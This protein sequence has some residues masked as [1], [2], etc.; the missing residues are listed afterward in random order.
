MS[1]TRTAVRV[2]VEDDEI[3]TLPVGNKGQILIK[4]LDDSVTVYLGGSTVSA[5]NGF[6][7]EAGEIYTEVSNAYSG[8]ASLYAISEDGTVEL[9]I[10]VVNG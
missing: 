2:D 5:A 4:N 7:L 3:A 10:M 1:L 8:F 6:P 9:S